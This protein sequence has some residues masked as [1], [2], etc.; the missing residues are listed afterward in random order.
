MYWDG[1]LYHFVPLDTGTDP[2]SVDEITLSPETL[3]EARKY[4]VDNLQLDLLLLNDEPVGVELPES[5]V[6]RVL[7]TD[8]AVNPESHYK[9]ARMQ[10]PARLDTGLIVL[11]PPFISPGDLIRVNTTH[12]EYMERV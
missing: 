3:G 11:V 1:A 8:A 10:G 5:I 12:G 7:E 4:I 6:M 2:D 9:H